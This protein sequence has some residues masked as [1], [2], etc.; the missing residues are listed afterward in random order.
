[1]EESI[2]QWIDRRVLELTTGPSL[3]IIVKEIRK[4]YELPIR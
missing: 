1:M 2:Q 3:K 4:I